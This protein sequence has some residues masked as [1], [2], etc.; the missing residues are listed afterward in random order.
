MGDLPENA[1]PVMARPHNLQE[2]GV[3]RR[4]EAKF[5]P[6]SM[7]RRPPS[8]DAR[9]NYGS[10]AD[11]EMIARG[12]GG[13]SNVNS[14]LRAKNP[15]QDAR[16]KKGADPIT[17]HVPRGVHNPHT[18]QNN[19]ASRGRNNKDPEAALGMQRE[20]VY[21]ALNGKS[22]HGGEVTNVAPQKGGGFAQCAFKQSSGF[23]LISGEAY[24]HPTMQTKA[25]EKLDRVARHFKN[26]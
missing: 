20:G 13:S 22:R 18:G 10:Y 2:Y 17:G 12:V 23:N 21:T 14:H 8:S 6:I 1:S 24:Q 15:Q 5:D 19:E 7:D 4:I 9:A 11:Q 3:C 26:Q 16:G 25:P